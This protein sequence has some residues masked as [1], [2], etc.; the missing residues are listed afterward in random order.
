MDVGPVGGAR[1]LVLPH[2]ILE[3][4]LAHDGEEHLPD[5][6]VGVV[7]RRLSQTV[8]HPRLAGH[9]LEVLE[10]IGDD[11]LLGAGS[12]L[13]D[14]VDEQLHQVVG[15]L[16]RPQLAEGG[17]HRVA[18]GLGVRAQLH[19]PLGRRPLPVA[20]QHSTCDASEEIAR[21]ADAAER[22]QLV[23]LGPGTLD[24]HRAGVL[25]ELDPP[26]GRPGRV[27]AVRGLF[28]LPGEQAVQV[29][30]RGRRET[31]ERLGEELGLEGVQA[32]ADQP[33]NPA[34]RGR[35]HPELPAAFQNCVS[36]VLHPVVLGGE[37]SLH[38]VGES[39]RVGVGRLP[40][41][42]ELTDFRPVVPGRTGRTTRT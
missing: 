10:E 41:A 6:P 32:R 12:D 25:A 26:R 18:G 17:D 33:L 34:G 3:G 15:D 39:L 19:G 29:T 13:V 27:G 21:E 5:H 22:L 8:E 20:V 36:E 9:L 38:P 28:V 42:G 16:L 31:L 1:G 14:D 40:E 35:L 37:G 23:D 4:L 24:P 2:Q 7:D 11:L 30:P